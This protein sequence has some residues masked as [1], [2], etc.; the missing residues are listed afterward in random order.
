MI[1]EQTDLYQQLERDS[2]INQR[3]T[4][5]RK[6]GTAADQAVADEMGIKVGDYRRRCA[7]LGI[8]Q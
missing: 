8:T 7:E 4:A 5:I 3:N 1:I 2:F 6:L